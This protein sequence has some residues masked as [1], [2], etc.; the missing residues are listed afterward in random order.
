MFSNRW[1]PYSSKSRTRSIFSLFDQ[2]IEPAWNKYLN[3]LPIDHPGRIAFTDLS[4]SQI[5]RANGFNGL[6]NT[7][8]STV[9]QSDSIFA[10]RTF[11][12]TVNTIQTLAILSNNRRPKKVNEKLEGSRIDRR[13]EKICR[14][15]G[16]ATQLSASYLVEQDSG[17]IPILDG[18]AQP[19]A[20]YCSD[21]RPKIFKKNKKGEFVETRN[22]KY[23]SASRNLDK[24]NK[25]VSRLE[26]LYTSLSESRAQSGDSLVDLFY[27]HLIA[28]NE[29]YLET[30]KVLRNEARRLVDKRMN[31]TKMRIIEL[32][33]NGLNQ[34]EIAKS[35]GI[36]RQAVNKALDAVP[37]YYR[38]DQ[39]PSTKSVPDSPIFEQI[40]TALGDVVVSALNDPAIYGIALNDDGLIWVKK[41]K[42][43]TFEVG[44][45]LPEQADRLI[46]LIG[47]YLKID[48]SE[49]NYE[50]TGNL[51]FNDARFA[52]YLPPFSYNP[53]FTIQQRRI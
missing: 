53:I 4:L 39:K 50:V 24:F 14:F 17:C 47:Q 3:T 18:S 13:P 35:I 49:K 12:A 36:S 8:S 19:S 16:E 27:L 22:P 2:L 40:K 29:T 10:D 42:G 20:K 9:K 41:A 6:V 25:E 46:R 30:E 7:I 34:N 45:M 32:L 43:E 31:E 26:N 51:P 38:F 37:I 23:I 48:M 33:D 44:E 5:A 11:A 28:R 1:G 21:H 52:G 15:C